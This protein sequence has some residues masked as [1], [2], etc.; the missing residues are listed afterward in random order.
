[1]DLL[2]VMDYWSFVKEW[3][4]IPLTIIYLSTI[5]TI[6]FNNGNPTKT[7][8]WILVIVFLPVVGVIIYFFFGQGFKKEQYFKR[9]DKTHKDVVNQKWNELENLIQ[10]DLSKIEENLGSLTQVFR[11]LNNGRIAPP[12]T[13][14]EVKLLTNGE[15]KF[16]LFLEALRSATDHIHLEYYIFEEDKIGNEIISILEE[17]A[18]NGVD[19]RITVDDFGSPT[20]NKHKKRFEGTGVD[21]QTFLPVHFT[22]LANSNYR[23]HRKILIVDAKV[24]FVGGINISDKYIN[25]DG[26][27]SPNNKVYWRDTSVMIKGEAINILQLRFY[28]NWMMTDGKNYAIS[29]SKYYNLSKEQYKDS[30]VVSFGFTSPGDKVHSAMEAMMLG[31]M[32]AKKKVQICTPYFIPSDEFKTAIFIAVSAGVEVELIIPKEGDSVIVQQAS[33]SYLKPFLERGVKV[34]LYNKGFIHAK[35]ITIDDE[36]AYIGTVNLDYR[37]FFI[38]FEITSVLQNDGLLQEMAKHFEVDRNNSDVL[39]IKHWMNRPWYNRTFA[40]VCRLLAPIL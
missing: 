14:N 19:V 32:L 27:K 33:L 5:L 7:M 37:S 6:L 16:P 26:E 18:K 1:M 23:N 12:S 2:T 29:D 30:A 31:I 28:L 40:S 15:E 35:T 21:F 36:I 20:L 22:S 10:D 17:K 34:Y 8:A 11:Y 9:I 39:T 25:Q 13:N 38:N 24:A 4:W 3:S